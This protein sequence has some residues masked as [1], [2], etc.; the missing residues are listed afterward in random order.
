MPGMVAMTDFVVTAR[1]WRPLRFDDVIGQSHV[2]ATLCNAIAD[3]RLA[4]A[5][6]FSG[7]RGVGK[8]TTARILAKSVNCLK[9][10][11]GNPDNECEVCKEITDGRSFDVLEID[12]ASNRGVDE[13]RSLRE[14][15]RYPPVKG[16]Y[17]T[18]IIDEVH[19][20]TKEAFNALLKT[21]EEPPRHILFI[22]ATTEIH[23]VPSTI[24]SRCQRFEFR[25][26]SSAEIIGSLRTVASADGVKIEEDALL[27]IAKKADGSLRDAQSLFDQL[28]SLCGTEITLGHILR[29]LRIVDLDIYFRVT[30]LVRSKDPKGAL[31]L[32]EEIVTQGY[33]LREFVV[34]LQEHF[35]NILVAKGTGA[36]TLIEASDAFKRRYELEAKSF[37]IPD[38]LR[39]QRLVAGTETS[40]RYTSQ[41]RFR[42]EADLIQ[43]ASMESAVSLS[44]LVQSI[45]ELKKKTAEEGR[46][47]A[48]ARRPQMPLPV[49]TGG[50]TEPLSD[51]PTGIS[52]DEVKAQWQRFLNEVRQRRISLG[53]VIEGT[54]VVGVKGGSIRI[55]C[56]DDFVVSTIKRNK[57]ELQGI[58]QEILGARV[59]LDEEIDAR[60]KKPGEQSPP[61]DVASRAA[62]TEEHPVVRA[63]IRDLGAEPLERP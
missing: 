29:E 1:K 30:D 20:L 13:I 50:A 2:T 43:L 62:A 54:T 45:E 39:L 15:V 23:K 10:V 4:H 24:L 28:V 16:S 18:Y 27:L 59:H 42:L 25:R 36:T 21:L 26:L 14:A 55:G 6:L 32:I 57:Q 19:M 9:P 22:F 48:P 56:A 60:A 44:D 3:K 61:V 47:A 11:N 53:S 35:R 8:T 34:G 58:L 49:A 5:Y 41:A 38:L 63:L 37:S 12:G 46:I 7:P 40:L 31:D 51:T 52:E 33:D 17:K